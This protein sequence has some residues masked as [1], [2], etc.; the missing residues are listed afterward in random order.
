[1]VTSIQLVHEDRESCGVAGCERGLRWV[2]F[3][4]VADLVMELNIVLVVHLKQPHY[5]GDLAVQATLF[6]VHVS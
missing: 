5:A 3:C 2:D 6:N 4:F 1:M